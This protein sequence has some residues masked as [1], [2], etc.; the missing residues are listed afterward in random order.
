MTE[1]E[2]KSYLKQTI[3]KLNV[4]PKIYKSSQSLPTKP[5]INPL[6]PTGR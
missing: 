2:I 4:T 1:E 6:R 3:T 5:K